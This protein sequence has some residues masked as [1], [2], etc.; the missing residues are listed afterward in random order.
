MR[1]SQLGANPVDL[2][3][4]TLADG[5]RSVD[6]LEE[7]YAGPVAE[8]APPVPTPLK[9]VFARGTYVTKLT[10]VAADPGGFTKDLEIRGGSSGGDTRRGHR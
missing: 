6:G 7:S 10:A 4:Y 5:R 2:T 3:L 1:L 9:D 8:L